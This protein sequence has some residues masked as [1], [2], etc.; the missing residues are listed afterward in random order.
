MD[1]IFLGIVIGTSN[2]DKFVHKNSLKFAIPLHKLPR[3]NTR[4]SMY[5]YIMLRLDKFL[6]LESLI[7]MLTKYYIYLDLISIKI[8][9]PYDGV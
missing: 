4:A 6:N 7:I 2:K 5:F 1:A 3:D 9:F 8:Q